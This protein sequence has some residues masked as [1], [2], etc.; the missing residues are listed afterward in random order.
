[1]NVQAQPN[2]GAQIQPNINVQAQP[3]VGAQI[4]PNANL[5]VQSGVGA[6]IQTQ[7][8][9][10]EQWRFKMHNGTWWYWMPDNYWMIY[11]DGS[12][13]RFGAAADV[14]VSAAI[15]APVTTLPAPVVAT[16]APVY[17]APAQVYTSPSTVVTP[18]LRF[19]PFRPFVGAVVRPRF[20]Y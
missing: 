8:T 6:Q 11:R 13:T 12:W 5:Q 14:G 20:R 18:P 10:Q 2:V 9:A 17:T 1:V 4:Q 7:A 15:P 19:T 3:N 16:P